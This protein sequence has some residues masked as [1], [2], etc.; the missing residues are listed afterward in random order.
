MRSPVWIPLESGSRAN[1]ERAFNI[2][3]SAL[4]NSCYERGPREEDI[5]R[6]KRNDWRWEMGDVLDYRRNMGVVI[7]DGQSARSHPLEDESR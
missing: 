4:E 7:S 5:D 1:L 2:R 3:L 6:L